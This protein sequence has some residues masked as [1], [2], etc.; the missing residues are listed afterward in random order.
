MV[1]PA[2]RIF[3]S[4]DLVNFW[5]RTTSLRVNSPS[6]STFMSGESLLARPSP[7]T[8]SR[9]TVAPSANAFSLSTLMIVYSVPKRALVKPRLGT[10]R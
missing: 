5:A 2:L 3:S 6:P 7:M 10:R 9:S 4:A 1:P 8:A